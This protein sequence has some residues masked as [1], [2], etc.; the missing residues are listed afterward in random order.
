M[1]TPVLVTGTARSGTTLL[2]RIL[3]ARA[4]ATLA[5]DP[6]LP[7]MRALRDA[8]LAAAGLLPEQPLPIEDYYGTAERIARMDAVQA[9]QPDALAADPA[10]LLDALAARAAHEAPD[11]AAR[12]GELRGD[13]WGAL[14]R[15]A[16]ALIARVRGDAPIVGF[17]DVWSLEF[18][19]ALLRALPDARVVVVRRD[20]RAIV[21]SMQALAADDAGPHGHVLSYARHWR[22]EAALLAHLRADERIVAVSY[23]RLV[24]DPEGEL[25]RLC[26][27]LGIRFDEAMLAAG[28]FRDARGARWTANSSYGARAA[29]ISR[30]SAE[31]WR[32]TLDD[33]A[34]ALVELV[35]GPDMEAEGY[36]AGPVDRDA[37]RRALARDDAATPDWRSDLGDIDADLALEDARRAALAASGPVERPLFLF[38][39]AFDRLV[40]QEARR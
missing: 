34:R 37:A 4:D 6:Y 35:C 12:M 32:E 23:E 19:P 30:S 10:P 26:A 36:Q 14:L 25:R 8:A 11:L 33:D 9:T 29:G 17:K 7:L 40:G 5:S 16:F 31:R 38:E 1:Q 22:K 3:D 13:T 24:A 18:A 28:G 2:A 27:A 15:D 20:P 39:A 21:A